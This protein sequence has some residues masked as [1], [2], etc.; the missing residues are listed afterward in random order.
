M[1][2]R[3]LPLSRT[4]VWTNVILIYCKI[5]MTYVP[6]YTV[7]YRPVKRVIIM[8]MAHVHFLTD[9]MTFNQLA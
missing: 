3:D 2:F 7:P 6:R 4:Y 9:H 1:A 8:D 5:N